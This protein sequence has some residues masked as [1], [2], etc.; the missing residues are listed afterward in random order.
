MPDLM[1][2]APPYQVFLDELPACKVSGSPSDLMAFPTR[3]ED[4]GRKYLEVIV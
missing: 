4:W 1:F 2:T 3:T